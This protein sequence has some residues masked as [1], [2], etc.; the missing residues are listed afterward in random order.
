MHVQSTC[1]CVSVLEG[2]SMILSDFPTLSDVL[3]IVEGVLI[4]VFFV[5]V[6]ITTPDYYPNCEVQYKCIPNIHAVRKSFLHLRAVL[7]S[8]EQIKYVMQCRKWYYSYCYSVCEK[9]HLSC[10]RFVHTNCICIPIVYVCVCIPAL[11]AR[12]LTGAILIMPWHCV[13]TQHT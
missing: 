2:F 10:T 4:H 7:L 5:S 6:L 13:C 1:L 3:D 9:V 12:Q 11:K 8:D